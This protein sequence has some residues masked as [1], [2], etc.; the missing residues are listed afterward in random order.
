M[1]WID[2]LTVVLAAAG[3]LLA[4]RS[5]AGKAQRWMFA[6]F[7]AAAVAVA[8]AHAWLGPHWQT[9]PILIALLLVA[10]VARL[11]SL[12]ERTL[13]IALV[14]L[15]CAS[16]LLL[17]WVFPL[18]SLPRPTGYYA[19][20]T[21]GPLHWTDQG[22]TM[23]GDSPPQGQRRELELQIWYPAQPASRH[24]R[25][26]YARLRELSLIHSYESAI[27][28]NSLLHAPV[29][30]DNAAFPVLLFGHR[31]GGSRTQDTFLFEELASHGYV[32]VSIDHPLNAARVQLADGSVLRSD[33]MEALD[34]L[35]GQSAA[36]VQALWNDELAVWTADNR[37]VLDQLERTPAASLAGRLDLTRVGAFGHS[38]GGAASTALLGVDPRVRC[39]LNLDG[40]TFGGLD[41]RTT[42]PIFEI[43]EGVSEVRH[44]ETGT[45][46]ELDTADN[47]AV[48][49]S[50]QR[51]GGLRAY[52]A[53]TQH[54]DFT[55]QT[56]LSPLQRLTYTGPIAGER[57][58]TITRGL[59]LAFFDQTLKG[60]G[61]IP[62]Y[63]EVHLQ[64]FP[65]P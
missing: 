27:A 23:R 45:E 51:F 22:R 7:F 42:Q 4:L 60:T 48:D 44:P 53:G 34:H 30:S 5:R 14:V 64:R 41:H 21:S 33:R 15:L 10:L 57:I 25:A 29:A 3:V 54:L 2:P 20:G 58:R 35:E 24:P 16:S 13:I 65:A 47:L 59:V 1:S 49:T 52:I 28:T 39:A 56:L 6:L 36:A 55:D 8:C 12:R 32:V 43:Y 62:A 40:W 63:P 46:G 31:W 9:L 17:L 61:E 18:F 38:F 50:L 19:V 26:R 37:F 11:R